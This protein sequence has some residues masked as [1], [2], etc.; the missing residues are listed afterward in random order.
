LERKHYFKADMLDRK[1]IRKV[2]GKADVVVHLAASPLL[3]SSENPRISMKINIEG[4][5]D[6]MDASRELR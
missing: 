5:L 4:T 3:T 1:A 2:V 6:I